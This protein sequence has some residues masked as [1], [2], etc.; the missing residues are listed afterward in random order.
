MLRIFNH[1]PCTVYFSA[2]TLADSVQQ[3]NERARIKGSVPSSPKIISH[4]PSAMLLNSSAVA[5][6]CLSRY[7]EAAHSR[8]W[9]CVQVIHKK[10]LVYHMTVIVTPAG[11][12]PFKWVLTMK[13]FFIK[14]RLLVN[15]LRKTDSE[16][17][18]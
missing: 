3:L 10:T 2:K 5:W 16:V 18:T 9:C 4:I 13:V 6:R 15:I 17:R 14:N 1:R 11:Q 7:D 12:G 8:R